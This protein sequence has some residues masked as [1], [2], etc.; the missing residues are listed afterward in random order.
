MVDLNRKASALR[1]APV[2]PGDAPEID[3]IT[4]DHIFRFPIASPDG[5]APVDLFRWVIEEQLRAL[6]DII[7]IADEEKARTVTRYRFLSE[8]EFRPLFVDRENG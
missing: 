1:P 8:S 6:L 2:K 4:G 3:P 5:I 7:E